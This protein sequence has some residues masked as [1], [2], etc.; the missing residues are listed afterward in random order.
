MKTVTAIV[1]IFNEESKIQELLSVL[2]QKLALNINLAVLVVDDGSKDLTRVLLERQNTIP[3]VSLEK[4]LGKGK[5]VLEGIHRAN[6]PYILI[7]DGD[8]EYNPDVIDRIMKLVPGLGPKELVF[9]SRYLGSTFFSSLISGKQSVSS[10]SMNQLLVFMYRLMYGVKLSD[11][12]TGVKLY[13]KDFFDNQN[14][15]RFGFD[16]DHEIAL[17]LAKSGYYFTEVLV[18]YSARTRSEGKKIR[19]KDGFL[20]VRTVIKEWWR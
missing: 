12:L 18:E 6:T 19:A 1:P 17:R 14:F 16:G 11:T 10:L 3:W 4:N 20:A 13:R 7:F 5:A 8:L 15:S 2:N 9:A